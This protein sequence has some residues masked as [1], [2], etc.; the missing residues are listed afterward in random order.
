[1]LLLNFG[2]HLAFPVGTW[3]FRERLLWWGVAAVAP[4]ST[5]VQFGVLHDTRF[6][7]IWCSH[8]HRGRGAQ[9]AAL[10][11]DFHS[12]YRDMKRTNGA[13]NTAGE[14]TS[15]AAA[16]LPKGSVKLRLKS[17]KGKACTKIYTSVAR[18]HNVQ[19]FT[20]FTT[21]TSCHSYEVCSLCTASPVFLKVLYNS[22][23]WSK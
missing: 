8:L 20:P 17:N 21:V 23:T 11:G 14:V 5:A 6:V 15:T 3:I 7:F 1:M 13:A 18:S 9:V 10:T 12:H 19:P 2:K 16:V 22:L 4:Y